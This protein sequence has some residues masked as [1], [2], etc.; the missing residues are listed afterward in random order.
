MNS[1]VFFLIAAVFLSAAAVVELRHRDRLYF[2]QLQTLQAERDA[3][4]TEWGQLLLEQGAWAQHRRVE[5]IAR[6]QLDMTLPTDS[7]M[8]LLPGRSDGAKRQP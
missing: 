6:S 2:T 5:T 4:H 3:L 7:R 1:R 8:V